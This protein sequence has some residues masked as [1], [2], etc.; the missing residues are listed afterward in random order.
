MK[1]RLSKNEIRKDV[2]QESV[3]AVAG[4]VGEVMNIVVTAVKDV[5][6][7]IGA[8]ATDA[9]EIRDGARRA[10]AE[11]ELDE[12][13]VEDTDEADADVP[14]PTPVTAV[15]PEAAEAPKTDAE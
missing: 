6:S 8:L 13:D 2:V 4:T 3:E 14:A 12:E 10:R 5:A 11:L 1:D 15:T 7:S 9:F